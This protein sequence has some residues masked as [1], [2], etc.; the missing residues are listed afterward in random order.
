MVSKVK[1]FGNAWV[2]GF[3][4]VKL[5]NPFDTKIIMHGGTL[6]KSVSAVGFSE[7]PIFLES[8]FFDR[9]MFCVTNF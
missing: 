6:F 9:E 1:V 3:Q 5:K 2:V 4:M 7:K 8:V